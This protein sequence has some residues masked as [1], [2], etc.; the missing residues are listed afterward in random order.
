MKKSD[1]DGTGIAGRRGSVCTA[2][3]M[4]VNVPISCESAAVWTVIHMLV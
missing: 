1:L 2:A 3:P 4:R